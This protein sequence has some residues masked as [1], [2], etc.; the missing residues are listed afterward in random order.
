MTRI[1]SPQIVSAIALVVALGSGGAYAAGL[2]KNSVTSKQ[3]KNGAIHAQDVKSGA[4]T[5]AQFK[6]GS[7]TGAD[8]AAGTLSKVPSA[9]S[10][11]TVVHVHKTMPIDPG[12]LVPVF[13]RGPLS[14]GL[15]CLLA[16]PTVGQLYLSTATDNTAYDSDSYSSSRDSDLDHTD[17]AAQVGYAP[18]AGSAGYS[19]VRLVARAADGTTLDILGSVEATASGCSA[20][21]VVLG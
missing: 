6:D 2:A 8:V 7:L 20:D 17:P 12:T 16:P 21:L 1:T 4:L 10:V 14:I 9:A 13:T 5:G 18:N 15:A 11:D 19:G 3:I